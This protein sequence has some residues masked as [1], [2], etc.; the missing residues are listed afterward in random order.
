MA[1]D[2]ADRLGPKGHVYVAL[3]REQYLAPLERGTA[4]RALLTAVLGVLLIIFGVIGTVV[5]YGESVILVAVG[6]VA[7]VSALPELR[8]LRPEFE[9]ARR[10]GWVEAT[11]DDSSV[12]VGEPATFRAVLHARR[13]LDVRNAS[14]VAEA[15]RWQGATAG[16]VA[17]E[18][19]LPVTMSGGPVAAGTDWRQTVT[20]RIPADAPPSFY[21]ASESLRWTITLA[22]EFANADPWRRTWPMLVFPADMS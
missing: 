13:M 4:R 11:F 14:V 2:D 17:A 5:V 16:V 7:L 19:P 3:A 15:R 8:G 10:I 18:L 20:F 1:T 6:V 22:L 21:T 12:T 9:E